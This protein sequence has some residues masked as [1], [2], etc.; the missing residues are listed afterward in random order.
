MAILSTPSQYAFFTEGESL[1]ETEH[2]PSCDINLMLRNAAR[3]LNV[4]GSYNPGTYGYD[5]T[6]MDGVQFRIQKE[7]IESELQQLQDGDHEFTEQE[8]AAIDK[9]SPHLRKKY[10]LKIKSQKNDDQT[11]TKQ[12]LDL[13]KK[14]K[15][16]KT[17][18]Q[19]QNSDLQN[20][21]V[22]NPS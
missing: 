6:T 9:I 7:Q 13:I 22:S 20:E 4:R 19:V 5:D 15:N 8:L 14:Q 11:T 2:A 1:T 3:G 18:K 17:Q 21:E 12:D 16:V 10:N